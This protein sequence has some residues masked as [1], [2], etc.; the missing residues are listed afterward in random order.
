LVFCIVTKTKVFVCRCQHI[1]KSILFSAL[2][3]GKTFALED[4][5]RT[6]SQ[7]PFIAGHHIKNNCSSSFE[8]KQTRLELES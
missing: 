6:H 2:G 8:K 7:L 3:G 4:Q 5:T 1:K